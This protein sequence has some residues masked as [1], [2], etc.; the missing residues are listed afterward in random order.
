MS[1]RERAEPGLLVPQPTREDGHAVSAHPQSRRVFIPACAAD[2]TSVRWA[3]ARIRP[4]ISSIG[5]MLA[6]RLNIGA[7]FTRKYMPFVSV[8]TLPGGVPAPVTS[9]KVRKPMRRVAVTTGALLLPTEALTLY[10]GCPPAPFGHQS[11]TS[12]AVATRSRITTLG[13]ASSRCSELFLAPCHSVPPQ[14]LG[15]RCSRQIPV[16]TAKHGG[17]GRT[18]P[19]A[20]GCD[21]R[22]ARGCRLHEEL[23]C[24]PEAAVISAVGQGRGG[25][26]PAV[27]GGRHHMR[28][29]PLAG[30]H[31]VDRFP[32]P[33][34]EGERPFAV[35]RVRVRGCMRAPEFRRQ[36]LKSQ[37]QA[38]EMTPGNRSQ[39]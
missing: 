37:Q 13:P 36:N 5:I 35:E 14:I 32:D 18:N 6:P 17:G 3:S 25:V 2:A 34:G 16:K 10:S 27:K 11:R 33:G 22:L 38:G 24:H 7:P 39:T 26:S 1:V 23:D 12:A 20:G 9:A 4:S 30:H 31:N 21:C 29:R 28:D 8:P 15:N 19:A